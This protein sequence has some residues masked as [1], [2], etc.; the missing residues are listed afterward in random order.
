[1]RQEIPGGLFNERWEL[2][3]MVQRASGRV[4]R[5]ISFER[6]HA[7][8]VGDWRLGV[9]LKPIGAKPPPPTDSL[10]TLVIGAYPWGQLFID[11]T[12]IIERLKALVEL[13]L[14]AKSHTV[15]VVHPTRGEWER[16]VMVP[17]GGRTDS[18][19]VKFLTLQR[20]NR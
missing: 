5:A 16:E 2:V 8:L 7:S 20:E 12:L 9:S 18:I 19:F 10:G 17:P 11:D 6:I 1:M 14:L 3:G 13:P 4:C 15:R